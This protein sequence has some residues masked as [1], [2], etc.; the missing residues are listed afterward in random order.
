MQE[1]DA[2]NS[3]ALKAMTRDRPRE[4]GTVHKSFAILQRGNFFVSKTTCE[5]Y[6]Q[7]L[8]AQDLFFSA[9]CFCEH[10]ARYDEPRSAGNSKTNLVQ[11]QSIKYETSNNH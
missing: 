8:F 2:V 6:R 4:Q 3:G 9:S 1:L 7:S 10:A 11:N 5:T